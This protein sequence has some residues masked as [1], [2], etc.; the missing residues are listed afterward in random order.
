MR[1]DI[2]RFRKRTSDLNHPHSGL[3]FIFC[4]GETF[5]LREPAWMV[6]LRRTVE[7]RRHLDR[8]FC[9]LTCPLRF[10]PSESE[11]AA[12]ISSMQA[13]PSRY[14]FPRSEDKKRLPSCNRTKAILSFQPPV[15]SYLNFISLSCLYIR[16]HLFRPESFSSHM[17]SSNAG[18]ASALT[19]L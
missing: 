12:D 18:S 17:V 2:P 11:S 3:F 14:T 15:T 19:A 10:S 7:K 6:C 1:T 16:C 13:P 5:R 9:G 8:V 4:Q